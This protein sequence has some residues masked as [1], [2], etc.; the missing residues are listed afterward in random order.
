M[1]PRKRPRSPRR[2]SPRRH[3]PSRD[4]SRRRY[5]GDGVP[6]IY[7]SISNIGPTLSVDQQ[8]T[9]TEEEALSVINEPGMKAK[10]R[11]VLAQRF[12]PRTKDPSMW[13]DTSTV[14]S[15]DLEEPT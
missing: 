3:R 14:Y 10:V 2:T 6:N 13:P 11:A 8:L 15:Y 12:A 7:Y 1:P 4:S 5:R 9:P